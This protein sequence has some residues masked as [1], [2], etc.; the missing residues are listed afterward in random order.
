MSC[1]DCQAR[2]SMARNAWLNLKMAQALGHVVK[3]AAEM[4]GLKPK[5]GAAELQEMAEAK[6]LG[7]RKTKNP[8]VA[9]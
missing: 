5:T 4:V 6:P 3:G 2:V 7:K 8:G 9:G 1:A